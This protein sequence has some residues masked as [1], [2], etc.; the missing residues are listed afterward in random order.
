MN[1]KTKIQ[2]KIQQLITEE[3]A[4]TCSHQAML[5]YN[6]LHVYRFKKTMEICLDHVPNRNSCVLDVG[7]SNLTEMLSSYYNTVFSLGFD[8]KQDD[9][10]R[11][12]SSLS[13]VPHISFDLNNS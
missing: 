12:L 3:I 6:K 5:H 7:P 13:N 1:Y 9:V 10:H 8:N 4:Q 2:K 11:A